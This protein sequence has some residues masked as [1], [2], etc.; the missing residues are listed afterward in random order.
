MLFGRFRKKHG[1]YDLRKELAAWVSENIGPEWV[2]EAL[3]K[4]DR[5]NRG[6]P[7]GGLQETMVF[8]DMVENVKAECR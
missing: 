4:Y 7:I 5:L 6:E 8:I 1:L 2:D 3:D